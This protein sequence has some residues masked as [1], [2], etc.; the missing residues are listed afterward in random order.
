LIEAYRVLEDPALLEPIRKAMDFLTTENWSFFGS[1]YFFGE[2]HW[3]CIAAHEAFPEVQNEAY[4]EFC[5]DFAGFLRQMQTSE[6]ERPYGFEGTYVLGPFLAP[7]TT[8]V[9]GR[10]EATVATYKLGAA[11]G[12]PNMVVL[13]QIRR[14][15]S[16][17]V[18]MSYAADSSPLFP[19]ADLA[20]G[21]MPGGIDDPVVRIDYVQHAGNA[22][23]GGVDILADYE[24]GPP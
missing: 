10:T 11:M 17:L 15:L 16:F 18:R 14:S 20:A 2:E 1:K 9:A 21:G 12:R 6:G 22:L 8:P 13:E 3:T 23:L 24:L 5:E 4:L 19:R 7:R